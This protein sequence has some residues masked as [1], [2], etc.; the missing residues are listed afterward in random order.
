MMRQLY[1]MPAL[2]CGVNPMMWLRMR[3]MPNRRRRICT[4]CD[5]HR[6]HLKKIHKIR[7]VSFPVLLVG[8]PD[9]PS[10]ALKTSRE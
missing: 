3:G 1:G 2:L 5:R 8:P 7:F 4:L 6:C 10:G 9:T